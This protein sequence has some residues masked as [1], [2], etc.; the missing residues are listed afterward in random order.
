MDVKEYLSNMNEI[1]TLIYTPKK[2]VRIKLQLVAPR[3][4]LP[5]FSFT[6]VMGGSFYAS[7]KTMEGIYL[8]EFIKL[9]NKNLYAHFDKKIIFCLI[10]ETARNVSKML[11]DVS[12]VDVMKQLSNLLDEV[13]RFAKGQ[14]LTKYFKKTSPVRY[15]LKYKRPAKVMVMA[16]LKK[17]NY[18]EM[19]EILSSLEYQNV[20]TV[21]YPSVAES[22]DDLAKYIQDKSCFYNVLYSSGI[23]SPLQISRLK[24]VGLDEIII[25]FYS[26]NLTIENEIS[27]H[28]IKDLLNT[29]K[30]ALG[31]QIKV[32]IYTK[33][34]N[35]NENYLD[36]LKYLHSHGVRSFSIEF[37]DDFL[38][39]DILLKQANYYA[40]MYS[41]DFKVNT[42]GILKEKEIDRIGVYPAYRENMVSTYYTHGDFTLYADKELKYRLG[43]L[44]MERIQSLFLSAK[45]KKLRKESLKRK[46]I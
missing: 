22:D 44:S 42:K 40:Q 28:N 29:I 17:S 27:G 37:D 23:L 10:D 21:S 5:D 6:L 3:K 43:S 15:A 16:D 4:R 34:S 33:I 39:K 36:L 12:A 45:A 24:E 32:T 14:I 30:C 11:P 13:E 18:R 41:L 31:Y 26:L 9:L 7:L 19:H 38:H 2:D 35:K 46:R 8:Y 20:L 25:P 1:N